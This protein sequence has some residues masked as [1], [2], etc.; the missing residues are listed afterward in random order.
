MGSYS[1]EP[2]RQ[3]I[4]RPDKATDD[5]GYGE[6]HSGYEECR[7]E[8]IQRIAHGFSS[9]WVGPISIHGRC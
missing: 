8:S 9:P 6:L 1:H 3:A 5:P 4:L 2:E 7:P